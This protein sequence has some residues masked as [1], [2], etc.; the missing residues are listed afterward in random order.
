MQRVHALLQDLVQVKH[1]LRSPPST[2][3]R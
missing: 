3:S 1:L 2:P